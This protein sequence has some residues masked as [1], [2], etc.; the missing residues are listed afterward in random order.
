L[1]FSLIF[2]QALLMSLVSLKFSKAANLFVSSIWY[3]FLTSSSFTF[4]RLNLSI[5]NICAACLLT[6]SDS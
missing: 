4:L 5:L 3:C 6:S 2:S 1:L